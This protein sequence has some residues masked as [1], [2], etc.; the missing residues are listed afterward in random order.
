MTQAC[1]KSGLE[2]NAMAKTYR[3][4]IK[5]DHSKIVLIILA[6]LCCVGFGGA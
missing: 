6:G 2:L 1:E 3:R 4:A 5:V